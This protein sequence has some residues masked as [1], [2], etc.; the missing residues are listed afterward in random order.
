V[1]AVAGALE[2]SEHKI[3]AW[4]LGV[5]KDDTG[6]PPLPREFPRGNGSQHPEGVVP[7]R[8][9]GRQ[10]RARVRS[11]AAAFQKT[12]RVCF[13]SV[14]DQKTPPRPTVWLRSGSGPVGSAKGPGP[15]GNGPPTTMP[16]QGYRD[17]LRVCGLE[18]SGYPT[19][20]SGAPAR[21]QRWADAMSCCR[22]AAAICASYQHYLGH[23]SPLPPAPLPPLTAQ[24]KQ[25]ATRAAVNLIV[26]SRA[27]RRSG[28]VRSLPMMN[29]SWRTSSG[30]IGP[31]SERSA[32][33]DPRAPEPPGRNGGHRGTG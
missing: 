21:E 24:P 17:D 9:R 15:L 29:E 11:V 12:T 6:E 32:P 28:V 27:Q 26:H 4:G 19:S 13:A 10:G 3:S 8:V 25:M 20:A 22:T 14:M 30:V 7:T 18:A 5:C 33:P 31:A 1:W 16:R 2:R 23:R